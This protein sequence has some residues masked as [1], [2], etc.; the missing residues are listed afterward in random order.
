MTPRSK[1]RGGEGVSEKSS[2]RMR[3]TVI[4]TNIYIDWFNRGLHEAILFQA[5]AVKY[6]SAIVMMELLAGAF[7][8]QDRKVLHGV[9][10]AFAKTDRLL[11][12]TVAV[13]EE[14]GE[15]LRG[16]RISKS[17]TVTGA[18]ALA[19]DV[20]IAMSARSIGATVFTQNERDFV[21]IQSIRPFKLVVVP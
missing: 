6:L 5:G 8:A 12:P 10:A 18:S 21:V 11:L 2:A 3:R 4:D 7:S 20:L 17:Y 14:A 9:K 13:Y 15:V 1:R 19:N 16:L